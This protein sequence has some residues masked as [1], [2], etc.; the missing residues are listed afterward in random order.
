M[1]ACAKWLSLTLML[2]QNAG[3]VLVMRYS[4][5]QQ[6]QQHAT[7]YNVSFVVTLQEAFKMVVCFAMLATQSGDLAAAVADAD[8]VGGRGQLSAIHQN[9]LVTLLHL[10]VVSGWHDHRANSI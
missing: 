2:I 8:A 6:S 4:R 1:A 10:K 9:I 3:F 7:Q 5:K